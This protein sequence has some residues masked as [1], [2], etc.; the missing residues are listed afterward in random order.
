[1]N[2]LFGPKKGQPIPERT[3]ADL[4]LCEFHRRCQ[5]VFDGGGFVRNLSKVAKECGKPVAELRAI[6]EEM[7]GLEV[8]AYG[9]R[10]LIA[11]RR[12]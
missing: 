8:M 3:D 6:A 12:S 7:Y 10:G 2:Y 1:M 5:D 4:A 9:R 11:H